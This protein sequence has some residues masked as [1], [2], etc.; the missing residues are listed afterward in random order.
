MGIFRSSQARD[1]TEIVWCQEASCVVHLFFGTIS[2]TLFRRSFFSFMHFHFSETLKELLT[3]LNRPHRSFSCIDRK[4]LCFDL[5]LMC[6]ASIRNFNWS[7]EIFSLRGVM[8]IVKVTNGYI[9]GG[10]PSWRLFNMISWR[11]KSS[12][13]FVLRFHNII[14]RHSGLFW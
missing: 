4:R 9:P 1:M 2:I 3:M 13:S 8:N 12:I 14:K 6:I 10:Y 11:R 7:V 5:T